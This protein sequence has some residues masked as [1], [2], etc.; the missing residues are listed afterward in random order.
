MAAVGMATQLT[1]LLVSTAE[2]S[3]LLSFLAVLGGLLVMMSFLIKLIYQDIE[4]AGGVTRE[5]HRAPQT[6]MAR[7][8]VPFTVTVGDERGEGEGV[9]LKMSSQVGRVEYTSWGS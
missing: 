8:A 7:V 1:E 3:N 2:F 4:G 9:V 6:H 5:T